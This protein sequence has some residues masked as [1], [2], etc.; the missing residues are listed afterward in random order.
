M[1]ENNSP[2][3]YQLN[4]TRPETR[5]SQNIDTDVLIVGGGIAGIATLFFTLKYTEKK[6][7]LLEAH[8]IAHGATGHNAGY[9]TTGFEKPYKQIINEYGEKLFLEAM[10]SIETSWDLLHELKSVAG[11]DLPFEKTTSYGGYADFDEFITDLEGVALTKG[12]RPT[13]EGILVSQE[14]GWF[15]RIPEHLRTFCK[16]TTQETLQKIL[17]TTNTYHAIISG[18]AAVTNSALLSDRV[19]LY[20]M[21]HYTDRVSVYEFSPIHGLELKKDSG[22]AFSDEYT[23]SFKQVVLATNGFEHFFIKNTTG[24][25]I[26]SAFHHKIHG[27]VGYMSGYTTNEDL[28]SATRYFYS[29]DDL[30]PQE[31][32]IKPY[33]Y[34]SRRT[35]KA[36]EH[37]KLISIGGPEVTLD[38][39]EVYFR[40]Y[41]VDDS[42][43]KKIDTF[44]ETQ[45]VP[46]KYTHRFQWHGLMGYTTS[47]LRL[48]GPEPENPILLYNLGC[49]GIGILTSIYGGKKIAD[50][51]SGKKV[52][53]SIFDPKEKN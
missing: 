46:K 27:V 36:D 34:L 17:E 39:R 4:R 44:M 30:T 8:R 9:V 11:D 22:T 19:L 1:K 21:E 42:F 43:Y 32:A 3:L 2:W 33:F 15:A 45:A 16:E 18:V 24:K 25:E 52:P 13:P 49:N 35:F 51:L 23:V 12:I 26:D 50:H 14:S 6:V 47:G 29:D 41:D 10:E 7:C 37:K 38:Q 5:L 20:C 28:P 53:P 31:T 48:V 40:Q